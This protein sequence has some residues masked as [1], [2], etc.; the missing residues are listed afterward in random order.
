MNQNEKL[1]LQEEVENEALRVEKEI[2]D[3]PELKDIKVSDRMEAALLAKI[4]AYEK[5]NEQ[6]HSTEDNMVKIV[7][8]HTPNFNVST[9][10]KPESF[11]SEE[12][13]EALRLGREMMKKKEDEATLF[14]VNTE[15]HKHLNSEKKEGKKNRGG[16]TGV[17]R[18]PRGR[19]F[20]IAFVAVLVLVVGTS[21]T[22]VGS[23]SYL[24]ELWEQIIGDEK[25]EVLNDEDMEKQETE[26]GMEINIYKEIGQKLGISSV[27]LGYKP[28][29]MRIKSAKIDEEQQQAQL[30]YDYGDEIIRYTVY[31]N[32]SDSSL[33]QKSLDSLLDTFKVNNEVQEISV[34]AYEV[35]KYGSPRYIASF[36]YG[37][38]HY[39]LK[40][41]LEKDELE[42]IL[43]N[44]IY[45]DK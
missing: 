36:D 16:K 40:G 17:F 14:E 13:R 35:D 12:D 20:A 42:K 5:K 38:I 29:G 19:R 33:G 9:K 18:M 3:N 4:Q 41:I 22:S 27:R 23:K 26:D 1:S 32:D 37:G 24:K 28:K 2:A 31:L 15:Y 25:V 8:E 21:V 43:Q 34:E 45:F 11:L 6:K 7:E 39:Q 44:L 30:F 10:D